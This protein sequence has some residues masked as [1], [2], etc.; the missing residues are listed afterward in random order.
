MGSH[1]DETG[2]L[3]TGRGG[4]LALNRAAGGTWQLD[5]APRFRRLI[6]QRVRVVGVRADFDVLDVQTI[7]P[8]TPA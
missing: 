8:S 3:V 2:V 5:A 7:E 1:H 4:M 6:G